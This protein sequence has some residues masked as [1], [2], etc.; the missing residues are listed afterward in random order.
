[1]HLTVACSCLAAEGVQA[2]HSAVVSGDRWRRGRR[3]GASAIVNWIEDAAAAAE[4]LAEG[5]RI[6][7]AAV[8]QAFVVASADPG[9]GSHLLLLAWK[10]QYEHAAD[11]NHGHLLHLH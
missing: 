5:A 1:M 7:Q 11:S 3:I 9:H 10:Q 8:G 6:A 2:D 4:H